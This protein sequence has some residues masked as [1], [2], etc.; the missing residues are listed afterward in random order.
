MS[1]DT[2]ASVPTTPADAQPAQP[3][4][5][6]LPIQMSSR[7]APP[8]APAAQG[9]DPV[10]LAEMMADNKTMRSRIAELEAAQGQEAQERRQ[11][12]QRAQATKHQAEIDALTQQA[13]AAAQ[14][15]KRNA[16]KAHY[17]GLLKSDD[18]L[19]LVPTVEFTE[20]GDLTPESVEAL[21][22]FRTGKPEL[23]VQQPHATTPMSQSGQNQN[24]HGYDSET[25]KA[26]TLA[27]VNLPGT[28][29]HWQGRSNAA[30]LSQL[31]G[32]NSG[33]KPYGEIN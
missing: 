26:M 10:K 23:F 8:A 33:S 11:A 6:E 18:Y 7:P 21:D 12:Q 31:V 32:H 16:V 17:R 3:V 15:A 28:E 24:A 14:S 22:A 4:Q 19:G 9:P 5:G 27:R 25:V 30:I 13:S 20:S 1:E 2:S 29:G